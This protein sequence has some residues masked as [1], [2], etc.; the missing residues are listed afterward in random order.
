MIDNIS[1]EHIEITS[2]DGEMKNIV[3]RG[4]I[5]NINNREFNTGTNLLTFDLADESDG[6]LVKYS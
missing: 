1:E 4:R 3:L 6:I 2:I 5:F